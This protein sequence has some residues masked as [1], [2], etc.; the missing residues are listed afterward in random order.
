MGNTLLMSRV[1]QNCIFYRV[2]DRIS[3]PAKKY[4]TLYVFSC[5]QPY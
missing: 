2:Y 3:V 1:G 4:R 5:G